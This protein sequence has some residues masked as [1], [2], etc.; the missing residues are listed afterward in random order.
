MKHFKKFDYFG[1]NFSF[2]YNGYN[3]YSTRLGGFIYL[4]FIIFVEFFFISNLISFFERKNFSLNIYSINEPTEKI[5]L[6]NNFAFGI[7]CENKNRKT[8]NFQTDLFNFSIRYKH[9]DKEFLVNTKNCTPESFG[10]EL[11]NNLSN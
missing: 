10:I 4:I 9:N 11:Y 8:N 2:N 3:K 6:N 7:K 5:E 1:E